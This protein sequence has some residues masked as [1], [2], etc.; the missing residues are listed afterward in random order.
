[1]QPDPAGL[2]GAKVAM[3]ETLNRYAYVHNDPVNLVDY[4]GAE[5][6]RPYDP[7]QALWD[8]WAHSRDLYAPFIQPEVSNGGSIESYP[9]V[10]VDDLIKALQ[11]LPKGCVDFF[12]GQGTINQRIQELSSG[13]SDLSV[14]FIDMSIQGKWQIPDDSYNRTY[15]QYWDQQPTQGDVFA[16]ALA[17]KGPGYD[18]TILLGNQFFN[19]GW[20]FTI[21]NGIRGVFRDTA[22]LQ[23]IVLVHEYMHILNNMNEEEMWDKWT[24]GSGAAAIPENTPINER[25]YAE[26]VW[27]ANGCPRKMQ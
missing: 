14:K 19:P 11:K 13:K 21:V 20:L 17:I 4:N 16:R 24:N 22:H 7:F 1:M 10:T 5:A 26:A 3:P 12:G 27:M 15:Q 23:Q 25:A 9:S 2:K 6:D 8:L 18:R